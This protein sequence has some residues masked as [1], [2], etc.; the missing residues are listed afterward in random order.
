MEN[1]SYQARTDAKR[2]NCSFDGI[3]RGVILICCDSVANITPDAFLV[4][5]FRI[6]RWR[7]LHLDFWM[8]LRK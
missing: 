6:I 5:Q 7:V 3:Q 4:V 8:L 2:S 1:E